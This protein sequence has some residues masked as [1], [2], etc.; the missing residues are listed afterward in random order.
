[1]PKSKR[2]TR[3]GPKPKARPK[4]KAP[5]GPTP[6]KLTP[7]LY[8]HTIE[9]CLDLWVNRLGFAK[10]VAMPESGPADFVIL[11][12]GKVEVMYQ[13]IASVAHD[14]PA[15]AGRATG[16]TNLF[17]EVANIDAVERALQ[18][19]TLAVPR[20]K[21]FYGSTEVGVKDAGGNTILFAQMG[22]K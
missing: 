4:P 12:K 21:T 20:R 16:E 6:T 15:Y 19:L 8:V 5:S 11:K 22:G 3:A 9:P 2:S 7:V 1:M 10:T 14:I 17:M 13:T 18:G